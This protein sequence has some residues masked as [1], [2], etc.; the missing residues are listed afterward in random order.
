MTEAVDRAITEGLERNKRNRQAVVKRL[1]ETGHECAAMPVL[2]SRSP[3][4][5]L[6]DGNGLP[7]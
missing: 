1:L 7:R 5:M 6:Y 2:D 4:D 3:D